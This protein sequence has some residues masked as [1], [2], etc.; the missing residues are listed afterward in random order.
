MKILI[1]CLMTTLAFAKSDV[2]IIKI[3][4]TVKYNGKT[5]NKDSVIT[6]SGKIQTSKRSFVKVRI[7]KWNNTVVLGP[8]SKM[9][10][11]LT[12]DFKTKKVGLI[13]GAFRWIGKHNKKSKDNGEIYTRTASLGVRGTDFFLKAN[14]LLGESEIVLFDGLVNFANIKD[15]KD[16]KLITKGQWGG[17]GGRYGSK[18]K[19]I[20][21]LPSNVIQ[22]FNKL[23]KL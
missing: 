8:N 5:I 15:E 17:I 6:E 21:A 18:V 20:D 3:R 10:I 7:N 2:T 1:L 9:N 16:A 19:V 23:L 14:E 12:K 11:D 22:H 13:H 4:G